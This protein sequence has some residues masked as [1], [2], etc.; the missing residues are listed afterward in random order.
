MLVS[1]AIIALRSPP[2]TMRIYGVDN[3]RQLDALIAQAAQAPSI[4]ALHYTSAEHEFHNNLFERAA[5]AFADSELYSGPPAAFI[6]IDDQALCAQRG[7]YSL[8]TTQLWCRGEQR[9]LSS[10][11]DLEKRLDSLGARKSR[12]PPTKRELG[13]GLPSAT[14]V[15][16]IDFTGGRPL[17]DRV[18]RGTTRRFF[19]GSSE[20]W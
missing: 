13:T 12:R 6:L 3:A 20:S 18:D 19:P 17:D 16:D 4:I 8:P 5:T 10:V 15:D 2:P 11:Y 1:L 7:V 9:E 14:A